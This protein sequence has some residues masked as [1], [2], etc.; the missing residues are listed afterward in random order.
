MMRISPPNC[1]FWDDIFKLFH[2][3]LGLLCNLCLL[4]LTCTSSSFETCSQNPNNRMGLFYPNNLHC[5][6]TWKW[7]LLDAISN[8]LRLFRSY[9]YHLGQTYISWS[10][11][12]SYDR[13][14]PDCWLIHFCSKAANPI[15]RLF[16][17]ILFEGSLSPFP[18]ILLIGRG[19]NYYLRFNV[20]KMKRMGWK[21][22]KSIL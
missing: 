20:R 8:P 16:G 22:V 21:T 13:H 19:N 12:W 14:S 4:P 6:S 9:Q 2:F 18:F 5:F 10:S 15:Q 11:P 1:G 17:L 3:Y 7:S